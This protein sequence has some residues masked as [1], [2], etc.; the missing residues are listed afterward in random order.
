MDYHPTF[1][2]SAAGMSLERT[3][4]EVAALNLA[5]AHTTQAAGQA[6]FTPMRVVAQA[7]TG[8]TFAALMDSDA[9][10]ATQLPT[11]RIEPAQVSPRKVQEPGHPLADAQG[12]V[13]YPG[14]DTATEMVTMMSA[15]RAY[16][17]NVAAMNMAR[18]MA[19][20]A[21][22]IGGQS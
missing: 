8:E 16:E 1:A 17:A 2:I 18:T 14:V 22:D 13:T 20:K 7:S 9:A 19:L 4:V 15:T 10:V 3:R 12:F 11:F 21:L 6:A 5:N